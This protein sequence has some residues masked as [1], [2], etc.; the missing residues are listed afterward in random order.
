MEPFV[1]RLTVGLSRVGERHGLGP[2][3]DCRQAVARV[4]PSQYLGHDRSKRREVLAQEGVEVDVEQGAVE[5][6]EHCA[7]QGNIPF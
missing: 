4:G 6:E 2:C 5:I 1:E 7:E 3:D